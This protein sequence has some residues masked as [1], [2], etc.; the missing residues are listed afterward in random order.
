MSQLLVGLGQGFPTVP[1]YN[2]NS[3]YCSPLTG[4]NSSNR[5]LSIRLY[6]TIIKNTASD[7]TT[8]TIVIRCSH[9]QCPRCYSSSQRN[10]AIGPEGL[11][12]VACGAWK[13]SL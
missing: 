13:C 9:W 6:S 3:V 4:E 10:S 12:S 7:Y 8:T 2:V 11:R 5:I 1:R